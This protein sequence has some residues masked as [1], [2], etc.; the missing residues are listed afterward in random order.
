VTSTVDGGG[1]LSNPAPEPPRDWMRSRRLVHLTAAARSM[2]SRR[3]RR[4]VRGAVLV[5]C[6]GDGSDFLV[7][8]FGYQ[9]RRPVQIAEAERLQI[10]EVRCLEG[11]ERAVMETISLSWREYGDESFGDIR[12]TRLPGVRYETAQVS[13]QVLAGAFAQMNLAPEPDSGAGVVVAVIDSD[14]RRELVPG[15]HVHRVDPERTRIRKPFRPFRDPNRFHGTAVAALIGQGA[16]G[17]ELVWSPRP[18]DVEFW[19]NKQVRAVVKRAGGRP[20]V[21]NLSWTYLDEALTEQELIDF[22]YAVDTVLSDLMS[23]CV[24]VAAAGNITAGVTGSPMGYPAGSEYVLA[25]AG[26]NADGAPSP[27]SRHG[28]DYGPWCLAPSG[29]DRS[30]GLIEVANKTFGGTSMACA[31]ASALVAAEFESRTPVAMLAHLEALIARDP[32]RLLRR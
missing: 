19:L 29:A 6:R 1:T 2:F 4:I 3:D 16:P 5:L 28:K 32:E 25:V 31:L 13:S 17:A 24:L 30:A 27:Q 7:R 11:A 12:T 8:L 22:R 20:V 26:A 14:V 23:D 9:R 15:L 21:A 10:W 18:V